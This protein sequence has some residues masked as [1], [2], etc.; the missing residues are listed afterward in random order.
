M[1]SILAD[2]T[3][4][5]L[6]ERV[7]QRDGDAW[8]RMARLYA[9][10]V[11]RWA[12]QGGLQASDAADVVQNVFLAVASHIDGFSKDQPSAT[13]RGWLWTIARNQIRL[14]YRQQRGRPQ[15]TGGTDAQIALHDVPEGNVLKWLDDEI[16]PAGD[17]A[18][19]RLTLR[20]LES[21]RNDFQAQTWQAFMRLAVDGRPA[22]EV[23]AE[24]GM[25]P[26]AVRQAK[27]R[28]LCRLHDELQQ[29]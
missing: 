6:L 16:E 18:R 17:D 8:S 29:T 14:F 12:R 26:A 25:T 27:Y 3:S 19:Q 28:I 24:L 4:T 22:A 2:S 9:P 10:L 23:A 1:S 7:R 11:Y 13:F 5:S 15:A 21:V 20:A